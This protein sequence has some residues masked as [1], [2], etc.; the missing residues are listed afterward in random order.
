MLKRKRA[1]G[2]SGEKSFEK[3]MDPGD[4]RLLRLAREGKMKRAMTRP[5]ERVDLDTYR[6][7]HSAHSRTTVR[8][9][10][11]NGVGLGCGAAGAY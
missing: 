7:V 5:A 1:D 2:Q 9:R 3:G 8:E 10:T 4:A 11:Q 6:R